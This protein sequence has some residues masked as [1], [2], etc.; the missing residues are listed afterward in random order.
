MGTL[1]IKMIRGSIGIRIGI[2]EIGDP[3]GGS[4]GSAAVGTGA[5]IQLKRR[6]RIHGTHK[7]LKNHIIGFIQG[8]MGGKKI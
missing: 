6:R 2:A 1:V 3:L 5:D 8:P 4:P 7:G